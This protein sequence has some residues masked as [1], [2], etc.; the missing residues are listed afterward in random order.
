MKKI[1]SLLALGLTI[2]L[3]ASCS[4][5]NSLNGKYYDIYDG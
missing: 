5:K 1:L 3:L 4:N 2:I